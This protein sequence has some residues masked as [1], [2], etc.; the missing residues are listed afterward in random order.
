MPRFAANLSMMFQEHAFLDRFQAAAAAGF[1]AV[2]YLFPYDHAPETVAKHLAEN[3][4][5]Q[6]LFNL[7]PGD[8]AAGMRGLAALPGLEAVFA[9]SVERALVYARALGCLKL[10]VMA[11]ITTGVDPAA[12]EACYVAN[13]RLA[14]RRLGE[15]GITAL[16]EP[17]N[18]RDMPGYFL[19]TTDQ[20]ARLI[21]AIAQPNVKLQFDVYHTQISEGDLTTRLNRLAPLIGHIQIAGVPDRAEPDTGEVAYDRLFPVI[22]AIGY[23]GFVGLEYRPAG[24]TVAGLG[25]LAAVAG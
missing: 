15:A 10:H 5:E 20:A 24:D 8:W 12:A 7:P 17:I 3:G 14:A 1:Q 21:E 2:E 11:G 6:S 16:I 13:L 22:D 19:N 4:L 9:E 18:G 25:W 23:D